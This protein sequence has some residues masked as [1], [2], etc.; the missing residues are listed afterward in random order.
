M[1]ELATHKNLI[2]V[3]EQNR[4]GNGLF[5]FGRNWAKIE[6]FLGTD[7]DTERA[8]SDPTMS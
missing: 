7:T 6:P 1:I 3:I 8:K 2:L 4:T 5:S